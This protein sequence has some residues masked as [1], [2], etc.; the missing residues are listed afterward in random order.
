MIEQMYFPGFQAVVAAAIGRSARCRMSVAGL[1]AERF[2]EAL[3]LALACEN[4][5]FTTYSLMVRVSGGG[6]C[7]S[8]CDM[9]ETLNLSYHAIVHQV[10]R[11]PYFAWNRSGKRVAV[12]LNMDG[13][14]KLERMAKRLAGRVKR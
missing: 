14:K 11:S 6:G 8:I 3:T 4:V 12:T 2:T 13:E 7:V 5:S 10:E 9:V 1:S